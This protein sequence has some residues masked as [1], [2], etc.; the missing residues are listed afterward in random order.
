VAAQV[1][2][3]VAPKE[4]LVA[5]AAERLTQPAL[6][7][8][9]AVAEAE[10]ALQMVVPEVLELLFSESRLEPLFHSLAV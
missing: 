8:L 1:P 9:V 4:P 10:M 6:P 2:L 7:T 3:A 5:V